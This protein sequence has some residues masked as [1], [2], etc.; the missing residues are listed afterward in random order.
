MLRLYDS[1]CFHRADMFACDSESVICRQHGECDE[2]QIRNMIEQ[3]RV[4]PC[5]AGG[6][7]VRFGNRWDAI[8]A[9]MFRDMCQSPSCQD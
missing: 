1:K 8:D 3:L 5:D 9:G 2:M 6:D 4:W 7:E